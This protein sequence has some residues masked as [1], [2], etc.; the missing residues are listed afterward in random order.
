MKFVMEETCNI[1]Q[2]Y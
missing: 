2:L 1:V